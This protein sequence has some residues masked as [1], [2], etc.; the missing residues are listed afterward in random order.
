M[1]SGVEASL[2]ELLFESAPDPLVVVDHRAVITL[3]NARSELVFGVS[4]RELV[5]QSIDRVIAERSRAALAAA[6]AEHRGDPVAPVARLELTGLCEGRERPL[7][8]SFARARGGSEPLVAVSIRDL[9]ERRRSEDKFR[10]LL[11]SAPDAMVIV[12]DTGRI[13]LV[14]AQTERLFGYTRDEL[15][16]EMV[17]RL[18]PERYRRTHVG[19]RSGFASNP[20]ART[21]ESGLLL[22]AA[23]K[24]GTEFPVEVSLSP[25][26]TDEG[27]F[28]SSAIRDVSE[29]RRL[30]DK[31]REANRLKSEFLANMSHELRTPLNAI[32]GFNELIARGKV[33][34]ISDRQQEF[35]ND[36][37]TSARHLLQLINDILDLAKVESGK[38][39]FRP[40]SVN[41]GQLVGEV[42]DVLR[43]LAASKH[44]RIE[45]EV[46]DTLSPVTVD[47]A[48]VKQILYNFV[49]NAIKFTNEGGTIVVRVRAESAHLFRIEVEDTGIGIATADLDKLFHEFQQLD[50]GRGRRYAGTGLGLALTKRIVAGHR[51][52]VEVK[53]E[54]G[55]GSTFSAILP[56][57]LNLE[58]GHAE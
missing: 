45:R 19:L 48:R 36:S 35:L 23:R 17:E 57:H 33:G 22:R 13:V 7:E 8:L 32:I 18:I 50:G 5:G 52:H 3:A 34:P 44:I 56:R 25:L 6:L 15:V 47:P 49:S 14:N 9:A 24:D 37:L 2:F 54:V 16:G 53:S 40:Q 55:V 42:R 4:R 11:E 28:V 39:E 20:H 29:R 41:L 10:G 31:M 1:E 27:L 46:D 51:G 30:E 38:M 58:A 26:V 12:D 43:G 21:M